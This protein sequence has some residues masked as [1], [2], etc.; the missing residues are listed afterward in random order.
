MC[1]D[2]MSFLE[3]WINKILLFY[4]KWPFDLIAPYL[5]SN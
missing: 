1:K 2:E 3:L 4:T 5:L